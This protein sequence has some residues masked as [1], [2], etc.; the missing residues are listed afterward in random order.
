MGRKIQ[1]KR[2]PEA[3]LPTLDIA[4]IGFTT[5]TQR[6][7]IGGAD[8]N[9]ELAKAAQLADIA[10]NVKS[11]G[12]KGD[13]VTDDTAD[14]QEAI[15]SVSGNAVVLFPKGTY[16]TRPL[17][18]PANTHIVFQTGVLVKAAA[19][20]GLS[21]SMFKIV[22]DNVTIDGNFAT[23]QMLKSE[24]TSGE[25]RHGFF[26]MGVENIV[27]RNLVI[28]DTG[29]DGI[30]IG[31]NEWSTFKISKNVKVLGCKLDNNRRQ[32]ISVVGASD[33][34]IDNCTIT[35]TNGT[36]P[37]AG[38]DIEPNNTTYDN[39][40]VT[41]QNCY[42]TDNVGGGVLVYNNSYNVKVLNNIM[43]NNGATLKRMVSGSPNPTIEF[44]GNVIEGAVL[45][46]DGISRCLIEGNTA[47]RIVLTS[48]VGKCYYNKVI[49]NKSLNSSGLGLD[50]S[51][52][53]QIEIVRNHVENATGRGISVVSS[54]YAVIDNNTVIGSAT[55]YAIYLA[56]SSNSKVINNKVRRDTK[57]TQYGIQIAGS[58]T[59][60]LIEDNDLFDS[61]TADDIH[62]DASSTIIGSNIMLDGFK[63]F[64]TYFD[65][66][67][68]ASKGW[69]GKFI[70]LKRTGEIGR[71][72]SCIETDAG[73]F[74]FR[75]VEPYNRVSAPPTTGTWAVGDK[76]Y[77]TSPTI[78]TYLGWVCTAGGTPGTW[79]GFG[80]VSVSRD[81]TAN[82]PATSGLSRG[83]QYFDTTLD[84]DGK[85]IWWTGL[86]WVD[87]TGAAV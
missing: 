2:G 30:I 60:V 87:A 74:Q 66:V 47:D 21:D 38:V 49:G 41:V 77:H 20:Y 72:Y 71:L 40:N 33:V 35:N 1:F 12:A 65:F 10:I 59:N 57:S 54:N 27:I 52:N 86:A 9:V 80:Q 83:Y 6:M 61:A 73:T 43:K 7:F 15:N 34:L 78:G 64:Y 37:Q 8:G 3:S 5:D 23:V 36:N 53:E 46:G 24:Y 58:N 70:I 32:G 42:M 82:R 14:I 11:L 50:I 18:I 17:T 25:Q 29:G 31:P 79:Q 26:I 19:G 16:I 81:V 13:G 75:M 39:R 62:S 55:D 69:V 22:G 84:P 28:K 4:E 45:Y 48:T 51:E 76:V 85:P 67:P 44:K 63:R 68:T 56:T